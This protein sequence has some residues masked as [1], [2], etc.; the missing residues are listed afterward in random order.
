MSTSTATAFK[1]PDIGEGIHEGEIVQWLV[2]P[3]QWVNE[4][5]PLVEVMTDKVT[6]EIPSPLSGLLVEAHGKPG[7][8]VK[9]GAVIAVIDPNGAAQ[10]ATS[11]EPPAEAPATLKPVGIAPLTTPA[12]VA[13]N[14]AT[15]QPTPKGVLAA[16]ATRK[17]A[18]ELGV[19]LTTITGTGSHGRITP[20]DVRTATS[21]TAYAPSAPQMS[22]GL[23]PYAE[24][25]E[26]ASSAAQAPVVLP[27]VTQPP[28]QGDL[29]VPLVG[30]RKKIAEH[31][32]HSKHTAPHFGYVDEV[33]MTALVR[34][35]ASLKADAA[36]V[37]VKLTYLPFIIQ[38]VVKALKQFPMLNASLNDV[39]GTIT[40]K[41]AYNIGVA[42]ATD[43]GL[44]VPVI[45]NTDQFSLL[46]LAQRITE[47]SEK[48]RLNKLSP[49]DLQ[50]GTFTLT[51]IGSI[52]G[53]FG[54]PI[55]N[56]PEVGILGINK[57]QERPV[58]RDGQVV[59]R[60][61][62]Y[63][64]LSCDHRVVDGADAAKFLNQVIHLLEHPGR[65]M[66]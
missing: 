25:A 59:V 23:S 49:A 26:P 10:T 18:R 2:Q 65:L 5:Q 17:L 36:A 58:V 53:L 66:L 43:A 54:L 20:D 35:R 50:G 63:F 14:P 56:H 52:G 61:M 1:L 12:P 46:Q 31:L 29:T 47:L 22:C 55:I 3:G 38:A 57:I 48:A 9:V 34:L 51:S 32:V 6:A 7:E 13:Q 21:V 16:P 41:S 62:M 44:I 27:P 33:D 19:D 24:P 4:D 37:G 45:A 40:Y 8:V 42:T 28:L 15:V 64:S 60:H 11:I 30:I 39:A